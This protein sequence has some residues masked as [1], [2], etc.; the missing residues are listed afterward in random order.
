MTATAE[1]KGI[2]MNSMETMRREWG[3][4]TK[5]EAGRKRPDLMLSVACHPPKK[6]QRQDAR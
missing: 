5:G 2:S 1:T 6:G 4:D 3:E